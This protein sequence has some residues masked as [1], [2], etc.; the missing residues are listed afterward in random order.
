MQSLGLTD[1]EIKK[2]ADPHY[3]IEYFPPLAVNDLKS[4]GMHVSCFVLSFA[5]PSEKMMKCCFQISLD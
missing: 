1:A 2:F 3:W 5:V 4:L